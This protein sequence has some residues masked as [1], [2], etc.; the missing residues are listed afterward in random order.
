[1][2]LYSLLSH[3]GYIRVRGDLRTEVTDITCDSREVKSGSM[4]VCLPGISGE[5]LWK[6]TAAKAGGHRCRAG[7]RAAGVVV[8]GLEHPQHRV[9]QVSGR[10]A[11]GRVD[12]ISHDREDPD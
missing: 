1:M 3:V 7:V 5:G 10:F 6:G 11:H 9:L 8:S 12:G 2:K 4:F